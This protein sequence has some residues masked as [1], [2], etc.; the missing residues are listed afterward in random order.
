MFLWNRIFSKSRS[1]N[2]SWNRLCKSKVTAGS[3]HHKEEYYSKISTHKTV[4][5]QLQVPRDHVQSK[6]P[7]VDVRVVWLIWYL[8]WVVITHVL[9]I[10]LIDLLEWLEMAS[11]KLNRRN[12]FTFN[13]LQKVD[14]FM[15]GVDVSIWSQFD[16]DEPYT[17]QTRFNPII[18]RASQFPIDYTDL[19][20]MLE[21]FGVFVFRDHVIFE[22]D[23]LVVKLTN[24]DYVRVCPPQFQSQ[25]QVNPMTKE[26]IIQIPI[27]L[28]KEMFTYLLHPFPLPLPP[29]SLV[30]YKLFRYLG[31]PRGIHWHRIERYLKISMEMFPL[32]SFGG[33]ESPR[34]PNLSYTV[35]KN[36]A[37]YQSMDEV[38]QQLHDNYWDTQRCEQLTK[39]KILLPELIDVV[40][41]FLCMKTKILV[42][43]HPYD[44]IYWMS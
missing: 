7:Y 29:R 1:Y 8:T 11:V 4:L 19:R 16:Y 25:I 15:R 44:P 41:E 17:L 24:D 37:V 28:V 22:P 42:P 27:N 31:I 23:Y 10:E 20:W 38:Y 21:Q 9:K 36:E 6:K 34:L 5:K 3:P 13:C 2:P 40:S 39:S 43:E 35:V 14:S 30:G 18:F 12:V 26:S 33:S 32:V